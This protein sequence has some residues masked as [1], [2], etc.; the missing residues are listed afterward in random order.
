M[1][2][3]ILSR[4]LLKGLNEEAK[5]RPRA[6]VPPRG[7]Q[8]AVKEGDLL[9]LDAHDGDLLSHVGFA[10]SVQNYHTTWV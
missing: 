7:P 3:R 9:D 1:G 2:I 8:L 4:S 6:P 10:N 5:G